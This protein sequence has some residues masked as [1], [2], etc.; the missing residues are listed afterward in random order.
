MPGVDGL[1]ATAASAGC[2]LGHRPRELSCVTR[3][4]HI[5]A[6]TPEGLSRS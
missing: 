6:W 3:R 1:E 5:V 4:H 2:P